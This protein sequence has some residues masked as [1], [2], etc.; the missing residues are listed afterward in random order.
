M[1]GYILFIKKSDKQIEEENAIRTNSMNLQRHE[2]FPVAKDFKHFQ[3]I[4]SVAGD[5]I[6]VDLASLLSPKFEYNSIKT[7]DISPVFFFEQTK[8]NAAIFFDKK[9]ENIPNEEVVI[10]AKNFIESELLSKFNTYHILVVNA[11]NKT[12][13]E[14]MAKNLKKAMDIIRSQYTFDYHLL[15]FNEA[16]FESFII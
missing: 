1:S 9:L 10:E 8:R 3:Y 4:L 15:D 6:S 12:T 11:K 14:D 7:L 2:L 13:H 5:L 16:T